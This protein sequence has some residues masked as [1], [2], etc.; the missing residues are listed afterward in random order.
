MSRRSVN[1]SV[2]LI[3]A[4]SLLIATPAVRA[5]E[6]APEMAI[7]QVKPGFY[8]VSGGGGNVGVLVTDQGLIVVDTKNRGDQFYDALMA[9]IQTVSDQPVR[10]AFITHHHQ[11]HSGNIQNFVAAGAQV[12]AHEDLATYSVNRYNGDERF[13][14]GRPG[15]PNVTY[16]EK[17]D[18]RL[19]DVRAHAYYYGR[20]HTGAD[21]IV[22][23]PGLRVVLTGDVIGGQPGGDYAYG[24]SM[25]GM[26]QVVNGILSL[27]FDVAITGH[28]GVVPRADIED[29]KKRMDTLIS[30]ATAVIRRGVPK[31]QLLAEIN[32]DD[33]GFNITNETWMNR[34]DPL[35][36]ELSPDRQVT[37]RLGI[38]Q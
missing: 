26:Q 29:F 25:V 22:H 36:A 2:M 21:T 24:G 5:Q 12:I 37:G 14:G 32:T 7:E 28:G 19:G 6:G 8:M 31:E 27:D 35:Y 20:S 34:L 1:L 13:P 9:Q 38:R 15:S 3:V 18:I 30:R 4:V 16:S 11:D 23:F 10:Y 17:L 33:I